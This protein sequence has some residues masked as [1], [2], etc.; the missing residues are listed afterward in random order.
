[1]CTGSEELEKLPEEGFAQSY[2]LHIFDGRPADPGPNPIV[3]PPIRELHLGEAVGPTLVLSACLAYPALGHGT[4][5]KDLYRDRVTYAPPGV[6]FRHHGEFGSDFGCRSHRWPRFT[7]RAG[8]MR[9][10]LG[11]RHRPPRSLIQ[12]KRPRLG[13]E[14]RIRSKRSSPDTYYAELARA[15]LEIAKKQQS[16]LALP[17]AATKFGA[18]SAVSPFQ[19]QGLA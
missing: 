5:D 16:A 6:V 13:T 12:A 7:L 11:Q 17:H 8:Q 9:P 14:P 19:P 2:R 4:I 1:V 18:P 15:Q 3:L 10:Y